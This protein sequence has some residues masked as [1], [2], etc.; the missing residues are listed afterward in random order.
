MAIPGIDVRF[1][2]PQSRTRTP[3]LAAL[4][5]AELDAAVLLAARSGCIRRHRPAGT[6]SASLQP[7]AFHAAPDERADHR[8]GARLREGGVGH[9]T[10]LVVG[11]ALDLD[12]YQIWMLA[13]DA[14]HLVE[15]LVRPFL[16]PGPRR[17]EVYFV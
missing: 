11:V 15:Q 7:I 1:R 13:Q 8:F 12:H 10:A 5:D 2:D 9:R 4:Y 14:G 17:R 6:E 3:A 16:D